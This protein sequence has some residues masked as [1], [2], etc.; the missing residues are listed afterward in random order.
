MPK[1]PTT[2]GLPNKR[3][4]VIEALKL[5]Y[6]HQNLED[7]EYERRLHE[8]TNAQSIEAL[9]L[10]V[11]D[12]PADIRAS[13]FPETNTTTDTSTSTLSPTLASSKMQV[14]MGNDSRNP[15]ELSNALPKI[16]A[17]L[18][19]QTLDF[20]LSQVSETPI[21]IR[22]ES[23]LSSTVIDL[24]NENLKNKQI[25]IQINGALGDVKIML[26]RG[27]KI[28]RN[29]QML[30][31]EYKVQDK[32]RSWIKRLTGSNKKEENN[33]DIQLTVNILGVFWLGNVK[34]IY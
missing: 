1:E 16:S 28:Q 11:F 24:R 2:Y 25:N 12:F 13:I 17:I 10:V 20:R 3:E 4:K 31:S 30:G 32:Q 8:A 27:A 22:V 23:I 15:A 5:A 19:S 6:T 7:H 21:Y 34:I 29:I 26:P 18:S 33:E 14:I 9:K